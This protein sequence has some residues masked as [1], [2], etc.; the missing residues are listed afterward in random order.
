MINGMSIALAAAAH[1]SKMEL[2][3]MMMLEM[4]YK[5]QFLLEFIIRYYR[6]YQTIKEGGCGQEQRAQCPN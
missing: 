6:F 5:I 3:L 1:L 4:N 2:L